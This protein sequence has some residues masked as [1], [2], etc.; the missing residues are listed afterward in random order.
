MKIKRKNRRV[1]RKIEC[2][3]KEEEKDDD[4]DDD[5]ERNECNM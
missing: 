5:E 4:D 1:K 2:L 3:V